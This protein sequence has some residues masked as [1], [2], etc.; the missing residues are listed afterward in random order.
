MIEKQVR[1]T[2]EDT[3]HFQG[4][5]KEL[6]QKLIQDN[7]PLLDQEKPD[8]FMMLTKGML[9]Q[10]VTSPVNIV[11]EGGWFTFASVQSLAHRLA[12]LSTDKVYLKTSRPEKV[13]VT[14]PIKTLWKFLYGWVL[15]LFPKACAEALH[16]SAESP[17]KPRAGTY[18]FSSQ[19]ELEKRS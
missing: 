17:K 11:I 3:L 16:V 5:L 12:D 18:S 10:G 6:L 13:E 14:I 2:L 4:E 9:S 1:L 15:Y 7:R 8:F 19:K